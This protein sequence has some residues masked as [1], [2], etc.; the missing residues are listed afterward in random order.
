MGSVKLRMV[1]S[2][3]LPQDYLCDAGCGTGWLT[4]TDSYGASAFSL[5]P[6]CGSTSCESC[7]AAPC[8]AAA[9]V[10]TPLTAQGSELVWLGQYMTQDT[11]GAD[12]ACHRASCVP[13][14]R[15]RAKACAAVNADTNE[16]ASGSCMPKNTQLCAEVEFEFP[17]DSTVELVLKKQ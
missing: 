5:F 13:P 10:P 15:Y 11:C 4:I 17:S 9:C 8:A 6:A 1:P 12:Q 7:S 16:T 2:P 14:G 3:D